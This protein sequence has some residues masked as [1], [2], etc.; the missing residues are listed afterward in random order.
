MNI[1]HLMVDIHP[2]LYLLDYV[3]A[4][5]DCRPARRARSFDIAIFR[6]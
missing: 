5:S 4:S 2:A 6:Y 3:S 1:N